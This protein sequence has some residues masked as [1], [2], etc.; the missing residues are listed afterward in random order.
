MTRTWDGN[1]VLFYIFMYYTIDYHTNWG[2]DTASRDINYIHYYIL[3]NRE[4]HGPH[5]L[6]KEKKILS[7]HISLYSHLRGDCLMS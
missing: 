5:G 2:G 6:L 4:T 3:S 7:S 1:N